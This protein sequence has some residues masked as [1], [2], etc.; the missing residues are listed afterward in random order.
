MRKQLAGKRLHSLRHET[1]RRLQLRRLKRD[2]TVSD[3]QFNQCCQNLLQQAHVLMP[4]M[5][6]L[7]FRV[8]HLNQVAPDGEYIDIAWD[9]RI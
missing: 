6:G 4:L 7:S 3:A 9:F 5:E 2:A 8:A 1:E